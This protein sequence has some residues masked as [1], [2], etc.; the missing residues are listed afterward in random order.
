M[1]NTVIGF[2]INIEGIDNINQLNAQ[3]KKSEEEL[4]GLTAGSEAFNA[5]VKESTN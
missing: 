4:K 2:S 1:A 3:I 5:K